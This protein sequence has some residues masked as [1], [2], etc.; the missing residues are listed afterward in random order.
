VQPFKRQ[1]IYK[2]VGPG[3]YVLP[4]TD[5]ENSDKVIESW[6]T[7]RPV[8]GI[9]T[10]K[11]NWEPP[12][13]TDDDF[14]EPPDFLDSTPVAKHV[15]QDQC[16]DLNIGTKEEPKN[17]QISKHL[18]RQERYSWQRFFIQ[19][20][21][22]FAWSYKDLKGVPPEVCEHHINLEENAKPV[23]QRQRRLNPKY[24]LLVKEEI[25]KLLE[26]GFIYPVPYSKWVSPIVIVPKKMAKLEF[27]KILE[28]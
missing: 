22:T 20:Y 4:C 10:Q 9:R 16:C 6:L 15:P 12:Y 28:S 18:S 23:R 14:E 26:I 13:T 1:I 21:S 11:S 2:E 25:E 19:H 24:S 8:Y 27:A 5:D 3:E 17:I 7:D